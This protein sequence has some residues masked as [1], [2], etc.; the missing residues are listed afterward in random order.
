MTPE[1]LRAL[2]GNISPRAAVKT[3][4]HLDRHCV[5]FIKSS[6][7]CI[8][9]TS[10]GNNLDVS[11]KGDPAGFVK[12][13]DKNNIIIP[14]R[15]GNNRIDGLLNILQHPY[16]GLLFLI[17]S[18]NE[19]LRINGKAKIIDDIKL[20]QNYAINGRP[21]RTI[22]QVTASEVFLHCGKAPLRG[23]LWKQET[24]SKSRPVPNLYEII[25]DHAKGHDVP[26]MTDEEIENSDKM[27]LY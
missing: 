1:R 5:N 17:P 9:A 25:K 11:P 20:C 21:P 10:D 4:D 14:D 15:P 16:V 13:L 18:V 7:F 26:Q 6:T 23:G 27:T 8:I 2:Y 3:I 12:V 22:I 19:T 24:W